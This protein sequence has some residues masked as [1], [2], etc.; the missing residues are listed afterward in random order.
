MQAIRKINKKDAVEGQLETAIEL[1]FDRGDPASI[2]TLVGAALG[3]LVSISDKMGISD[4]PL[5]DK[6]VED[7]IK[8]EKKNEYFRALYK[9]RNFLKHA[10]QDPAE[11]LE[12]PDGL[13][14]LYISIALN[15]FSRVYGEMFLRGLIF[16]IWFV[17]F[18]PST[19]KEDYGE[20][21]KR[22]ID[23]ALPKTITPSDL[24]NFELWRDVV[25]MAPKQTLK[26]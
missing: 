19:Y 24:N 14:E 15:L 16:Q 21:L 10:D 18:Y 4:H 23:S 11:I 25:R 2:H 13:D 17:Y 8:P 20:K 6:W 26:F 1:F 5:S 3:I 7:N 9:I 22:I 12:I